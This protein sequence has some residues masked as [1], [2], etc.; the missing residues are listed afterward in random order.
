MALIRIVHSVT[1][2]S[3]ELL[4]SAVRTTCQKNAGNRQSHLLAET[5]CVGRLHVGNGDGE[6]QRGWE[7]LRAEIRVEVEGNL[8][9]HT[10]DVAAVCG[11]HVDSVAVCVME[12]EV[13]RDLKNL[14]D[15]AV[16]R[17]TLGWEETSMQRL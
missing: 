15:V 9:D 8:A 6:A 16:L 1:P 5:E 2:E 11:D 7:A 13:A 12:N 4:A 3:E 10:D 17:W 14:G